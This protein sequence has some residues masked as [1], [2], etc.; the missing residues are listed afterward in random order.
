LAKMGSGAGLEILI[1]CATMPL[2]MVRAQA[3]I[4]MGYF[5]HLRTAQALA[6][7]LVDAE[8]PVR[9]AAAASILRIIKE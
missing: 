3:A 9:L 2:P 6:T 7:L 5:P 8:Q 4:E 1:Q